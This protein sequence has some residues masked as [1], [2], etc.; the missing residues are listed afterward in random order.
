MHPVSNLIM[1]SDV[2]EETPRNKNKIDVYFIVKEYNE[3]L[4]ENNFKHMRRRVLKTNIRLNLSKINS[5]GLFEIH[6]KVYLKFK[7]SRMKK[8]LACGF[9]TLFNPK[10]T[11]LLKLFLDS[12]TAVEYFEKCFTGKNRPA[13]PSNDL[14]TL[15]IK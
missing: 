13:K 6:G 2:V 7:S 11:S 5:L 12:C 10:R 8:F 9:H 4:V 3:K 14:L 15:L 1:L